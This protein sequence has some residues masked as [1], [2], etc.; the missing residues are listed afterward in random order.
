MLLIDS[1]EKG[2]LG[3]SKLSKNSL[4]RQ[5]NPYVCG[6]KSQLRGLAGKIN[7]YVAQYSPVCFIRIKIEKTSP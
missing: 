6:N 7:E 2:S 1:L 4:P 5:G 3:A